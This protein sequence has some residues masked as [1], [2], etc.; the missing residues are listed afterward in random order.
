MVF[1]WRLFS[2]PWYPCPL[3]HGLPWPLIPL[4]SRC[5]RRGRKMH[6]TT[7]PSTSS[8]R[9]WS[10][11]LQKKYPGELKINLVGGPEAVKIQDQ[12][13]AAQTG[14]VDIVHTTNAYYVSLL[15]EADAMKLS[16]LRP[17]EESERCLG[18]LQRPARKKAR[19][20]FP[21]KDRDG[22]ALHALPHQAHYYRGFERV[23][24]QQYC[25]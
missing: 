11:R 9:A 10:S 19:S 3:R 22:S 13:H 20:L 4:P 23:Q 2:W 15:P 6:R 24:H 1:C 14:M 25:N 18:L 21:G 5:S 8:W 17:W 7:S 12:V 16:E